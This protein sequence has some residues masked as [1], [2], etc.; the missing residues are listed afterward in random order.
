MLPHQLE[1][2]VQRR[3]LKMQVIKDA[4]FKKG[5]NIGHI[6]ALVSRDSIGTWLVNEEN[7]AYW[8]ICQWCSNF[9][10]LDGMKIYNQSIYTFQNKA[11]K[12]ILDRNQETISLEILAQNEYKQPR[13]EN[14][15]WPHLL[16]E[17]DYQNE[18]LKN[19]KKF[20]V[21]AKISFDYFQDYMNDE[22]NN[23]HT[24][25]FQWFFA[26]GKRSFQETTDFFWFGIGLSDYP[27][28]DFPPPYQAID[29]G[30]EENTNKFI[31]IVGSENYLKKPLI[32]NQT[33]EFSYNFINEIKEAYQKAISLGYLQNVDFDDL[34]IISTNIGI[35][36]TGTFQAKYTIHKI[37]IEK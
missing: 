19:F 6:D 5:F 26:I 33:V 13:V 14:Q 17:Q 35:E 34:E 20:E 24:C 7:Q 8:K 18:F 2:L 1:I 10:L 3:Y 23:L 32:P 27:R 21:T 31:Y 15:G 36:M 16:L 11:K 28:Y 29:G 30:K 9:D 22:K 25:Q 12:I 37:N 4:T